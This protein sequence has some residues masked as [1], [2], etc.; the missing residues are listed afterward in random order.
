MGGKSGSSIKGYRYHMAVHMGLCR[1]P[2]DELV[3]IR[4]DDKTAWTGSMS[5][6][7]G[8]V[9]D[10]ST[11]FGGDDKEGGVAGGFELLMGKPTQDIATRGVPDYASRSTVY[12]IL[13]G[14][15]PEVSTRWP[16]TAFLTGLCSSFRGVVTAFYRGQI[17]VNNPYPKAWAFRV[18]RSLKGW[19]GDDPWYPSKA[20]VLLAGGAIRAMNPAHI[21]YE[22]ITNAA[23]G[24]GFPR[25]MLDDEAFTS[26]ANVLCEE[27]FGLCV[28]WRREESLSQFMQRILDH[29]GG[30]MYVDRRTGL[31]SL[32]LIRDDY[33]VAELPLF[34]PD[35]GLLSVEQADGTASDTQFNEVVVTFVSPIDGKDR[36]VRAQNLAAFQAQQSVISRK[37]DYSA[38]PTPDLALRVA[39][40]DLRMGAAGLKRYTLKMDRRAWKIQ[41]AGVFR[42]SDPSRGIENMVLRAGKIEDSSHTEGTITITAVQDV[43][44]LPA[45]SFVSYEAGSWA[46]PDR[47]ALVVSTRLVTEATYRDAFLVLGAADTGA[48]AA[49]AAYLALFGAKPSGLSTDYIPATRVGSAEFA[50]GTPAAWTPSGTLAAAIGYHDTA[51]V[52]TGLSEAV[53]GAAGSAVQIGDEVVRLD[54]WD[55]ATGAATIARGCLDTLPAPHPAGARVWFLDEGRGT[56]GVEYVSGESVDVRLLTRTSSDTLALSAAPTDTVTLAGRIARPYP[57]GALTVNGEPVSDVVAATGELVFAWAHRHRTQQ[58]DQLLE[59]GAAS[60]GPEPG[61]TYTLRLYDG[62]TLLRTESGITGTTWTYDATASAAD[63]DAPLLGVELEAVRDGLV[64]R[65]KYSFTVNRAAGFDSNFDNFFDG[66]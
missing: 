48:L 2:V 65:A 44:G 36:Q 19:M 24:R 26:T 16:L 3:E 6:D 12:G 4:V 35:T 8:M 17:A 64:S 13:F 53:E 62:A 59:H 14:A 58:A 34:S 38:I 33:D 1:G 49:D 63:G 56:D 7:G 51:I 37:N 28:A 23:W 25:W 9:I 5:D 61:T 29:I 30:V 21:I 10:A 42:I 20:T 39:Q 22:C 43:F 66:A 32:R 52:V 50:P 45:T 41:P 57:P 11:L 46:P 54:A 15:V 18:R 55:A 27:G 60:V 31:I 40:R 47:S